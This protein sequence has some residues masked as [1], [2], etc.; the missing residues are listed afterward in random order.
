MTVGELY[1]ALER[2]IPRALSCDWDNDGLMCCPDSDAH[3]GKVL[4]AL[5]VT[6]DTVQRAIDGGYHV[7][8]SHHPLIFRPLRAM[9]LGNHVAGRV[10]DL[11]RAGISVMSFH[12][13]LDAVEGGVNDTLADLLGLRDVTPFG[14][15]IGRVGTLNNALTLC[16]FAEKV[17][18]VTGAPAVI[19]ADAE[20]A[21]RRVALLGGS[22]S[23]DVPAA[24][25]AGA[26][27]YLTGELAYHWLADA[28]EAGINLLA[29]GHFYTENPVCGTLRRMLKE[30]DPTLT[31][32]LFDS[33]RAKLI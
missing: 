17:K 33:N 1:A 30:T 15:G 16:E 31:V 9:E 24:I 10:I 13:R 7:I 28:K 22:G 4:V 21:V 27:T 8:V 26:D 32:D 3:V 6:S 23:D 18:S 20:L 14:E 5:D 29:A 25:A 2:R 12:T 11:V 19:S